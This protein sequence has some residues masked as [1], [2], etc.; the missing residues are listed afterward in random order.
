MTKELMVKCNKCKS[1][2]DFGVCS[3]GDIAVRKEDR[4]I[5]IYT[6]DEDSVSLVY[7]FKDNKNRIIKLL[8]GD[9][10]PLAN[11]VYVDDSIYE[12]TIKE[13]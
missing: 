11:T 2:I 5:T 7:V 9:L 10:L 13:L 8:D 3:C 12:E 1:V 4:Y 6:D